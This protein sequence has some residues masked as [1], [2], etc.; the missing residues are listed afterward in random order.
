MRSTLFA[1]TRKGCWATS[2]VEAGRGRGRIGR[3][4]MDNT[5]YL[6]P[7][8]SARGCLIQTRPLFFSLLKSFSFHFAAI[9][10]LPL[11]TLDVVTRI[12]DGGDNSQGNSNLELQ[13]RSECAAADLLLC[14]AQCYATPARR[15][16]ATPAFFSSPLSR[17]LSAALRHLCHPHPSTGP[18]LPICRLRCLSYTMQ[19]VHRQSFDDNLLALF[20]PKTP[21]ADASFAF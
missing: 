17:T 1:T 9:Y 5:H 16:R 14:T 15:R 19:D 8:T 3:W 21:V 12:G 7:S 18:A 13:R 4:T 10:L 20:M 6:T 11:L 2:D